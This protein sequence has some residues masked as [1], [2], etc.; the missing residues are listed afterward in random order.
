MDFLNFFKG[1]KPNVEITVS[2]GEG[3]PQGL[4]ELLGGGDHRGT[5]EPLFML[6]DHPEVEALF[7]AG[8]ERKE[9]LHKQRVAIDDKIEA[10]HTEM[11]RQVEAYMRQKGL[12]PAGLKSDA[13]PCLAIKNGVIMHHIHE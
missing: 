12:W 3:L 8:R 13:D 5:Y 2:R 1:K 9:F 6:K 4:V 7:K 10:A 11:W